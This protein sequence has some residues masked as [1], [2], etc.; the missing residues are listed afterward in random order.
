MTWIFAIG[1]GGFSGY[2]EKMRRYTGDMPILFSVYAASEALVA[3]A[4]NVN[5][6]EFVLI[7]DSGFY[8]FVP[9]D[10]DDENTTY[11]IDQLEPGR[12]YEIIITNLYHRILQT[13][14]KA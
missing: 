9:M 11:T 10:S 8:E 2:T 3:A 5:E 7:P 1:T 14:P 6:E 12:D 13:V 4:V